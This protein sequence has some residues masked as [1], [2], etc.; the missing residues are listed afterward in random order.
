[1]AGDF[2]GNYGVTALTNGNY[3]VASPDWNYQQGAA[4]RGDGTVG[5]TGTISGH[6]TASA[7]A[8]A[9]PSDMPSAAASMVPLGM[10]FAAVTALSVMAATMVVDSPGWNGGGNNG[11]GAVTWAAA[12][13][14]SAGRSRPPHSLVKPTAWA[15]LWA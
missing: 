2:V 4:T 1:M 8:T 15:I 10:A 7:G 9:S 13:L 5:I 6:Q 12:R 3:V 11:K 14:G